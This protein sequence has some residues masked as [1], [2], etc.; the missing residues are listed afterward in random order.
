MERDDG[1][2]YSDVQHAHGT[3]VFG[4]VFARWETHRLG[5]FHKRVR[6]WE[7]ATGLLEKTYRGDGG[8]FEVLE[9]GRVE[10]CSLL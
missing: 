2:V 3:G 7:I 8:V 1:R 5:K 10:D 4:R 9:P 6:V